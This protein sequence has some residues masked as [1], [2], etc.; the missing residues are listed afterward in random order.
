MVLA[1]IREFEPV[2]LRDVSIFIEKKPIFDRL[3]PFPI[4]LFVSPRR[5]IRSYLG[6]LHDEGM[7]WAKA[8]IDIVVVST[9][10]IPYLS[11]HRTPF[12]CGDALN[13]ILQE[14]AKEEA[15]MRT[16]TVIAGLRKAK[17]CYSAK[18]L[19]GR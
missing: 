13:D 15:T 1:Y 17:E 8:V 11:S 18:K 12:S 19:F 2:A 5:I 6:V 9:S 3:L 4:N 16:D 10:K 7:L 14:E